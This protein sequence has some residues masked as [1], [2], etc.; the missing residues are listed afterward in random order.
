MDRWKDFLDEVDKV[1]SQGQT[2][3]DKTFT[4]LT[5]GTSKPQ[6]LSGRTPEVILG[7]IK[8]QINYFEDTKQYSFEMMLKKEFSDDWNMPFAKAG[9]TDAQRL[10]LINFLSNGYLKTLATQDKQQ[11]K[12]LQQ[13]MH[14]T[15]PKS[16]FKGQGQ[17]PLAQGCSGSGPAQN[18]RSGQSQGRVTRQMSKALAL[19]RRGVLK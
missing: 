19:T 7:H 2:F 17:K 5:V 4:D 1:S 6:K 14:K 13:K 10:S 12:E 11:W 3:T 18:T 16:K 15:D 9:G 8:F